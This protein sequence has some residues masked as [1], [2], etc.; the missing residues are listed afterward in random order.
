MVGHVDWKIEGAWSWNT[1]VPLMCR[2][3]TSSINYI[4]KSAQQTKYVIYQS[5]SRMLIFWKLY[6]LFS[7]TVYSAHDTFRINSAR[8]FVILGFYVILGCHSRT[9]NSNVLLDGKRL[10]AQ[11]WSQRSMEYSPTKRFGRRLFYGSL[12]FPSFAFTQSCINLV[13]HSPF[14][15]A[16][17]FCIFLVF[18]SPSKATVELR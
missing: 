10:L 5:Y 16:T 2:N 8:F 9:F 18:N 4:V 13:L 12:I 14:S 1:T 17:P 15:A 11:G 7:A 3:V 6:R